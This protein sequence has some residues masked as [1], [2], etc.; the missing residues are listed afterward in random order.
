M[1][2]KLVLIISLLTFVMPATLFALNPNDGEAPPTAIDVQIPIATSQG[3]TD[4]LAA[5]SAAPRGPKDVIDD[6]ETEMAAITERFSSRLA[7]IAASVQDGELTS[8]EGQ[9]ISA[10]EYEMA[11][12]QFELLSTWRE[13]LEQDLARR[14]PDAERDNVS[15]Q[16]NQIVM[17]ALPFSSLQLSPSLA[18]YLSLSKSQIDAM[19]RVMAQEAHNLQPLM[20]QLRTARQKL[21]TATGATERNEKEIKALAAAQANQLAKVIVAN[22]R[23]QAKLYK[24]LTPQQQRKLDDLKQTSEEAMVASR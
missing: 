17:A 21:L 1:K 18:H 9:K 13:M 3:L 4:V 2:S 11:Q 19:Q 8:E 23:M 5:P 10:E 12:M 24:I 6:Y 15:P 14:T 16:E 7:T 20:A 22:S